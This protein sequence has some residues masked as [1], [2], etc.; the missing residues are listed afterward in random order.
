MGQGL[1][2][3]RSPPTTARGLESGDAASRES[4]TLYGA[5]LQTGSLSTR[6]GTPGIVV[7]PPTPNQMKVYPVVLRWTGRGRDVCVSGSFNNWQ[8]K[9]PLYSSQGDFST[10]LELPEGHHQYKFFVDGVWMHD[11]DETTVSDNFG[12]MNNIMM[13]KPSDY[14]LSEAIDGSLEYTVG[15][16]SKLS[17]TPPGEYAQEV[18]ELPFGSGPTPPP[19]LPAQL[20]QA[21]LN[22]E[23]ESKEDPSLLA[24]PSHVMLN[25]LYAL[26]V[27]DGVMILGATH[28]YKQKYV[29]TMLYKPIN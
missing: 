25:H 9:L 16:D 22:A 17:S 12:G 21:I 23:P 8:T 13:V 7:Q 2:G 24:E 3:A 10:I 11:S 28:R 6:L 15:V 14:D 1:S 19:V 20:M 18:P 4:H 27:K 29:T 26:S 5:P